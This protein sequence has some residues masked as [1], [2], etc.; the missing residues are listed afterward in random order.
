MRL[1]SFC[2]LDSLGEFMIS[3]EAMKRNIG[4]GSP[5]FEIAASF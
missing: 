1:E 5:G 2:H 3:F 4:S